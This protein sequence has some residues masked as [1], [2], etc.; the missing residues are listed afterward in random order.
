M[1]NGSP[2]KCQLTINVKQK[3]GVTPA[4]FATISVFKVVPF[5]WWET[6]VHVITVTANFNGSATVTLDKDLKYRVRAIWTGAD[7][8]RREVMEPIIL[9]ICPWTMTVI[10]KT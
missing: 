4:P 1:Y 6:L 2:V 5:L 3:D 10:F 7:G 8:R 9:T